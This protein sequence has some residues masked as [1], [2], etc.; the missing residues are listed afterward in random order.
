ML[1]QIQTPSEDR[2][3][4]QVMFDAALVTFGVASLA[5]GIVLGGGM[6]AIALGAATGLAG[7]ASL[8]W[9]RRAEPKPARA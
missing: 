3:K 9:F 1:E 6:G 7:L 2:R 5:D 8:V 4:T